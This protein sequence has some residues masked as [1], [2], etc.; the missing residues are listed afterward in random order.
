MT[1][2]LDA[3]SEDLIRQ[4]VASGRYNDEAKVIRAALRALGEQGCFQQ[5]RE[6]VAIGFEQADRGQLVDYTPELREELIRSALRRA[7][8]G[9]SPDPDVVP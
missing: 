8:R 3:A 4:K 7:E 5:L 9:E 2:T 1:V 6:K